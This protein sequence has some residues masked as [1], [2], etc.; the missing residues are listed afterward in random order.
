MDV[1]FIEVGALVLAAVTI[2]GVIRHRISTKKGIGIRAIQ[3]AAVPTTLAFLLILGMENLLEKSAIAVSVGAIV[4][5]IFAKSGS[6][7][8]GGED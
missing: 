5:Y 4:G 3:F 1:R 6:D 8:N 2:V 7:N